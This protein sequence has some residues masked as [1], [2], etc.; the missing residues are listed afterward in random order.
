VFKRLLL[1]TVVCLAAGGFAT[2]AG[3]VT[4]SDPFAGVW[5]GIESP[6]GDGST[7]IMAISAPAT[8]QTR[9]WLYYETDASGYCG[10]GPLAAAGTA[11]TVGNLLTVTVTVTHCFNG[12]VGSS[13]PPFQLTMTSLGNGELD[14]GGVI[15]DRLGAR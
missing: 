3:A 8:G 5:I 7:D 6:V 14:W 12:S 4:A 2:S 11:T 15:F 10:G 1:L 13:P 9:T